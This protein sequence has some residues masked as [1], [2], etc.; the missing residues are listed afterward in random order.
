MKYRVIKSFLDKNTR[1]PYNADYIYETDDEARAKELITGGYILLIEGETKKKA[2][3][4]E[5]K[6]A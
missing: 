5:E 3:K 6:A 2:V 4:K 1:K